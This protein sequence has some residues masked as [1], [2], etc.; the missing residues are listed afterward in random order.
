MTIKAEQVKTFRNL[1]WKGLRLMDEANTFEIAYYQ[2]GRFFK[3][4]K[5]YEETGTAYRQTYKL[6]QWK[7]IKTLFPNS[8]IDKFDEEVKKILDKE[9]IEAI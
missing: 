4:E 2:I 1:A 5:Y 8:N 3:V 7:F 9:I 6:H